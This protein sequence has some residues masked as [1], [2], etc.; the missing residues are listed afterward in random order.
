[1]IES[2][3]VAADGRAMDVKNIPPT[4]AQCRP[5]QRAYDHFNAALFEGKLP[6]SLNTLRSSHRRY[7]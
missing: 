6:P 5:L 1:M 3:K 4:R 7:G 2:E